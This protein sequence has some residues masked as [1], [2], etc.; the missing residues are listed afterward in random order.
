MKIKTKNFSSQKFLC[1]IRNIAITHSKLIAYHMNARFKQQ[2][3]IDI[4]SLLS[5]KTYLG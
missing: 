3:E 5:F 1:N 4:M 2:R